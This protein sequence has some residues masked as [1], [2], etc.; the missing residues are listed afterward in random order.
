[1]KTKNSNVSIKQSTRLVNQDDL[2]KTV[3]DLADVNEDKD[4][5]PPDLKKEPSINAKKDFKE[6]ES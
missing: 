5:K 2:T 4:I 3:S 6:I 1:M